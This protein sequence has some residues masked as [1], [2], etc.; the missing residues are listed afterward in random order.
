M[1]ERPDRRDFAAF[2]SSRDTKARVAQRLRLDLAAVAAS[3]C[4]PSRSLGEGWSRRQT[5]TPYL[6]EA[7]RRSAVA[8]TCHFGD[9]PTKV[10]PTLSAIHDTCLISTNRVKSRR[11]RN[12]TADRR[13]ETFRR[14]VRT[15]EADTFSAFRSGKMVRHRI[16]RLARAH[17]P[18]R[19][20]L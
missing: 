4:L 3:L 20:Q 11:E 12:R 2:L 5:C 6:T 18:R 8:T 13:P 1:W 7:R 14:S 17:W 10:S 15:D 9:T 19:I 16:C